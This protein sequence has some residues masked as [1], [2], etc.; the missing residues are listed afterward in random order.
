CSAPANLALRS[1]VDVRNAGPDMDLRATP[2][3]WAYARKAGYRTAL[4]D[5]QTTGAP[6]NLLLPPE[7]ALIDEVETVGD[8]ID[9]DR[10]IARRINARL[11]APGRSFTY[12]VLRGVHFQYRDHV[13]PGAL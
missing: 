2:S 11:K 8:G 7:R 5:G 9:T 12:A 3:I 10:A 4:I 6:Q 1:G 13:P